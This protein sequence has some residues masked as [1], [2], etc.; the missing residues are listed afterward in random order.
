M[1]KLSHWLFVSACVVSVPGGVLFGLWLRGADELEDRV[2]RLFA[3][4][5]V[6]LVGSILTN[7]VLWSRASGRGSH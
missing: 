4:T 3:L 1:R 6:L 5:V 2:V 7:P